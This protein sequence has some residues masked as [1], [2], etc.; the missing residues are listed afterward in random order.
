MRLLAIE[1]HVTA[2]LTALY[3]NILK[4]DFGNNKT[5]CIFSILIRKLLV[6]PHYIVP[7]I[8]FFYSEKSNLK[9]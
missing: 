9:I 1:E 4:S 7:N 6:N 5:K 8:D 2:R 3:Q